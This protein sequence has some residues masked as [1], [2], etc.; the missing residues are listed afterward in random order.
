MEWTRRGALF[1]LAAVAGLAPLRGVAGAPDVTRLAG[2]AFGTAWQ[3]RARGLSD[4]QALAGR[5]GATLDRL[6]RSLSP[7]RPDSEVTRFNT[8]SA[9][10]AVSEDFARVA[11]AALD[12]AAASGGAFDPTL[13]PLVNRWGFGPIKGGREGDWRRIALDG[14]LIRREGRV[15]FDPCGIAKGHA[16]DLVAALLSARTDDWLVEIGGEIR[17]SGD[18]RIGISDPLTGGIHARIRPGS[19]AVAT[20]GDQVNG[21]DLG[22]GAARRWSHAI[23]PL[24]GA[25]VEGRIAS[26]SVLAESA[27]AADALATALW[28]MG[29]ARAPAHAEAQGVGLLLLLREGEG[30]RAVMNARFAAALA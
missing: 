3:V 16:V 2:R 27:M 13:G 12:H 19:G 8:V 15:T 20:S 11:C 5:I 25:P 14:A 22:R 6:D 10:M 24:T 1:G 17:V 26:V 9:E 7:F 18:W 23:D 29:E 28:V 30:L 21:F 4:P